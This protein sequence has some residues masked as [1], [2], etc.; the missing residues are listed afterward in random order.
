MIE[1]VAWMKSVSSGALRRRA[2]RR[3]ASR[4]GA[5]LRAAR[6]RR[7]DR[8]EHLRDQSRAGLVDVSRRH[9]DQPRSSRRT[10]RRSINVAPAPCA[11]TPVRPAPSSMRGSSMRRSASRISPSRSTVRSPRRNARTSAITPMA[12]TSARTSA[13]GTWRRRRA[14]TR[15]GKAPQRDGLSAADLWQR[16]DFDLHTLIKGSAMTYLP[17]SRLRR[18]LATVIG[19]TGDAALSGVLDQPGRGVRN[20]ARSTLSPV[21]EDAVTWA[22]RRLTEK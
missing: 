21:V 10:R 4:A 14:R 7:L 15:R 8:Q 9:R 19:N 20:A 3:Q 2:F 13:R 16:S 18:N 5:R 12:A 17:L 11:S 6:R 22:R 1:F